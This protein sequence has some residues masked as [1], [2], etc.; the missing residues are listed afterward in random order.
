MSAQPNGPCQAATC[1]ERRQGEPHRL[2]TGGNDDLLRVHSLRAVSGLHLQRPGR[3]KLPFSLDHLHACPAQQLSHA[4]HQ[5]LD[6]RF[7]ACLDRRPVRR[8]ATLQPQSERLSPEAYEQ[9]YNQQ[10]ELRLTPCP[11]N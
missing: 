8:H 4:L 11:Q 7:L 1:P 10:H 6:D 9:L 3:N 2:R 5:P